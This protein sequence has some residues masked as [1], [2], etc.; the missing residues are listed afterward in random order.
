MRDR[1]RAPRH[2]TRWPARYVLGA[3][4]HDE[5]H[6][7]NVVDVSRTGA[8]LE[9]SGP[10]PAEDASVTVAITSLAVAITR[11]DRAP[12]AVELR[13]H[14]RNVSRKHANSTRVGI[15]WAALAA[16]EQD[17]LALLTE[18]HALDAS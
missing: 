10:V 3:A 1:R 13:G 8:A 12:V 9:V 15:E 11:D 16:L 4:G 6:D 2:L 5:W 14:V 18:L 17:L 7:C